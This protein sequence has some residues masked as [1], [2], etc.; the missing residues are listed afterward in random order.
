MT[1][2]DAFEK[3]AVDYDKWF[4]QHNYAY[5]S[6]L[7]AVRKLLPEK[8]AG[9]EIGAGTG[10]FAIPLGVPLGV[11]P[12]LAMRAIARDKGLEVIEGAAE[13]L[14]LES[15]KYDYLLYVT[16]L[17]FLD[18]LKKAFREARRVLKS[19]GNIIIGLIDKESALGKS[20]EQTKE[21][22]RFYQQAT[23]HSV[24]SVVDELTRAGF[25]DFV[26]AQTLFTDPE[27]LDHR[28]T[29][30]EG[31]GEGAFVVLRGKCNK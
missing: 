20:Y 25:T 19:D 5:Q 16:T 9:I 11:E 21:F 26:F 15:D 30:K 17:C 14:P 7:D 18:S 2:I 6:E 8:G 22:S 4:E 12:S 27:Q 29:T 10:R 28:E 1:Q 31:Y 24:G 23:F 3:W 13:A